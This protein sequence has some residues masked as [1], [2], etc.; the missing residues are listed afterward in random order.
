M[1]V[2]DDDHDDTHVRWSLLPVVGAPAT[3]P[4]TFGHME[5]LLAHILRVSG[6]GSPFAPEHRHVKINEELAVIVI[7]LITAMVLRL[8]NPSTH[9]RQR[10]GLK[11]DFLGKV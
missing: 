5:E 7:R 3:L 10:R 4:L 8:D 9:F 11:I 6:R 2:L 1:A